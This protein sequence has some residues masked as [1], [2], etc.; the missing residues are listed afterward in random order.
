MLS[1]RSANTFKN[2]HVKQ[3][4]ANYRILIHPASIRIE[5]MGRFCAGTNT[6]S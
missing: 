6:D 1:G 2:R 5:A 3:S 4:P